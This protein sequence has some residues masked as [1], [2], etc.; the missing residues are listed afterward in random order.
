M[1]CWTAVVLRLT[2]RGVEHRSFVAARGELAVEE[3]VEELLSQPAA[4]TFAWTS[5]ASS[6]QIDSELWSQFTWQSQARWQTSPTR[7]A[8]PACSSDKKATQP[9]PR[10]IF[11]YAMSAG[12]AYHGSKGER[13]AFGRAAPPGTFRPGLARLRCP[14]RGRLRAPRGARRRSS[15]RSRSAPPDR[16]TSPWRTRRRTPAAR[17]R[18]RSA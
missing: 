14:A 11:R 9:S 16:G 2:L 17:A 6:S 15:F 12:R 13:H 3:V 10:K 5:S 18:R 4:S 8:Q 7:P 1:H